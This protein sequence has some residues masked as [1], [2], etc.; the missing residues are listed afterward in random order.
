[1]GY[2]QPRLRQDHLYLKKIAMIDKIITSFVWLR[3]L[4]IALDTDIVV[5]IFDLKDIKN[6]TICLESLGNH[7]NAEYKIYIYK[8]IYI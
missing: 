1:M 4:C 2:L 8:N 7:K 5:N 6:N 3:R